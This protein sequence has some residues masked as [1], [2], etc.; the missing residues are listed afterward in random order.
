ML[1]D[2]IYIFKMKIFFVPPVLHLL[3]LALFRKEYF[4]VVVSICGISSYGTTEDKVSTYIP[5][6]VMIMGCYM[7]IIILALLWL[8]GLNV[9]LC[10]P[11]FFFFSHSFFLSY[12]LRERIR[13]RKREWHL[14]FLYRLV[15][16][17]HHL[18]ALWWW[19]VVLDWNR[20]PL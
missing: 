2:K 20:W 18:S 15:A 16:L 4:F 8:W 6:F 5:S 11:S 7:I 9:V 12:L 19:M 10:H 1:L 13:G 14:C 17:V 3:V